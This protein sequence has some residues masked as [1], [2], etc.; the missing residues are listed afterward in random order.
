MTN[1]ILYTRSHWQLMFIFPIGFCSLHTKP[2]Q[3]IKT[4]VQRYVN[5]NYIIYCELLMIFIILVQSMY[6][7]S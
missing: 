3:D 5:V 2:S 4:V 6:A 7:L 1:E